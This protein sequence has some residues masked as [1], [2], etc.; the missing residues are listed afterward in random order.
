MTIQE[1]QDEIISELRIFQDYS[2]MDKYNYLVKIG[3]SLPDMDLKNK[4]EENIIKG[5]QLKVWFHS[6]FKNG[7][8]FY[9]IES[10]SAIT[11][12]IIFLLKRVLSGRNPA[13]IKDVD[14]Y[15]I[16]KIGLRE[17][18]SPTRANGLWKM[19]NRIKADAAN[20]DNKK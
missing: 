4:T 10:V 9:D 7:K 13:E 18:F 11:N 8:V 1:I 20:Y 14:L 17:N 2:W 15:F 6:E 16:D 19:E 3:K 12:G 5:C